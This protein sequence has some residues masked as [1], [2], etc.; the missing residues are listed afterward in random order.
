MRDGDLL[1]AR[2]ADL[3][4]RCNVLYHKFGSAWRVEKDKSLFDYAPGQSADDF[5][6]IE[7]PM[8]HEPGKCILPDTKDPL[9][10][11]ELEKAKEICGD[12]K[13]KVD[14][15]NCSQDVAVTGDPVFAK[16]YFDQQEVIA[17]KA[18]EVPQ[19]VGPKPFD[20]DLGFAPRFVW[21][22]EKERKDDTV[23]RY[24]HCPWSVHETFN[25][26]KHCALTDKGGQTFRI[27]AKLEKPGGYFWKIIA[28]DD[29][30]GVTESETRRFDTA[31]RK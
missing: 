20:E 10:P 24:P 1:G 21:K 25:Q 27:A 6:N 31:R 23:V 28:E 3:N 30:G 22:P 29:G 14:F 9:D 5:T 19:L 7:W 8:G 4:E 13:N 26:G 2:P 17:R 11:I 18:S 16:P 15:L 12:L